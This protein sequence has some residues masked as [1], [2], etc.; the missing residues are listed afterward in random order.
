M[1]APSLS[2]ARSQP[3]SGPGVPAERGG[4]AGPPW[5]AH[6]RDRRIGPDLRRVSTVAAWHGWS[7]LS[8]SGCHTAVC[9]VAVFVGTWRSRAPGRGFRSR[10]RHPQ[11][12][13]G[14][15]LRS[16][17]R[18]HGG[19]VV[20]RR[21]A[22]AERTG[23]VASSNR[24]GT[25]SRTRCAFSS[26][27]SPIASRRTRRTNASA[28]QRHVKHLGKREHRGPARA[29]EHLSVVEPAL[30]VG[31]ARVPSSADVRAR[32]NGRRGRPRER[33]LDASTSPPGL[34]GTV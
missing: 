4:R 7:P 25:S 12:L 28:A 27:T 34:I 17:R 24:A 23:A 2:R 32:D 13:R 31:L 8:P 33:R 16:A 22:G 5:P 6:F 20:E 9:R 18:R 21:V 3:Q 26:V 30:D 1:F 10:R 11:L 19:E 14:R 29:V 15:I